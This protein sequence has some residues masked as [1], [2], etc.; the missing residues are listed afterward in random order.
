MVNGSNSPEIDW[1]R[2]AVHRKMSNEDFSTK[3]TTKHPPNGRRSIFA[4]KRIYWIF[5]LP[6]TALH[7]IVEMSKR[8]NGMWN[9]IVKINECNWIIYISFEVRNKIVSNFRLPL[10]NFS[11]KGKYSSD[12]FLKCDTFICCFFQMR[13]HSQFARQLICALS[14]N[15]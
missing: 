8:L 11:C 6:L 9:H 1:N 15:K 3:V 14:I 2:Q 12:F 7:F 4:L 5:D 13:A 10:S